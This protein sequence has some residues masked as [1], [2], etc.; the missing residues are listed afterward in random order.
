ME[1]LVQFGSVH[2][3]QEIRRRPEDIAR[4]FQLLAERRGKHLADMQRSGRWRR[5]FT[6]EKL[7]S[8]M[9]E[10]LRGIEGWNSLIQ[11]SAKPE[12][13]IVLPASLRPRS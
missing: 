5:Y 10:T 1:L 3:A 9:H 6:E 7:A 8:E 4:Q 2:M 13:D 12:A 11:P